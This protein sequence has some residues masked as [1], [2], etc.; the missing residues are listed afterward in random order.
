MCACQHIFNRS[1]TQNK[2]RTIL[3]LQDHMHLRWILNNPLESQNIFCDRYQ[4]FMDMA[5]ISLGYGSDIEGGGDS[6]LP[7]SYFLCSNKNGR[8]NRNVGT[9]LSLK[10]GCL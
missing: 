8:E 7:F 4:T 5:W 2:K 1:Y 9:T 6:L 10:L 3:S